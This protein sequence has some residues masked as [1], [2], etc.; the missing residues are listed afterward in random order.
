MISL[1]SSFASNSTGPTT[2]TGH[3]GSSAFPPSTFKRT[4]QCGTS[5]RKR[6]RITWTTQKLLLGKRSRSLAVSSYITSGD[7]FGFD[8]GEE[9]DPIDDEEE[10]DGI[11]K[12]HYLCQSG[13]TK[14]MYL[15][16][17]Y[18]DGDA[19]AHG[20]DD[21]QGMLRGATQVWEFE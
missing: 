7:E 1:L 8:D 6:S 12:V 15:S 2:T 19:L 5:Q 3:H 18:S 17:T 14:Y 9:Q 10:E 13:E 21:F 11:F 16:F 20:F 4:S